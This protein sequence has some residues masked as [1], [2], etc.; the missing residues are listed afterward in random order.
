MGVAEDTAEKQKS[1]RQMTAENGA[2]IRKT[3]QGGL[4]QICN[5]IQTEAR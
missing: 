4:Q 2:E 1:R 5:R 3:M